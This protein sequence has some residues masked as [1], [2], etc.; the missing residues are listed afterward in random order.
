MSCCQSD[1]RRWSRS[2]DL[3]SPKNQLS[4]MPIRRCR[5]ASRLP[6]R[7]PLLTLEQKILIR[8]SWQKLSQA[9]LGQ[10]IYTKMVNLNDD[11]K[12]LFSKDVKSIDRHKR[13]FVDLLHCAVD[14]LDDTEEALKPFLELIGKGHAEFK[15]RSKDW[16]TFGE[17]VVT[18]IKDR[19]GGNSKMQKD[20]TKAWIILMSFISDRLGLATKNGASSPMITPRIQMLAVMSCN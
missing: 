5:S 19:N 8:K 12:H 2:R 9:T 16:D 7:S 11:M 20:T 1:E 10:L 6:P 4:V 15:I 13:Y 17:A 3:L 14:N 18:A